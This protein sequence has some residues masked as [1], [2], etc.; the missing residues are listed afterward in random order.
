MRGVKVN[1]FYSL[2]LHWLHIRVFVV[3]YTSTRL[4][5][6]AH[7]CIS[8]KA[9]IRKKR[10]C[11]ILGWPRYPQEP[12]SF[13]ALFTHFTF[14]I[15]SVYVC[16][17]SWTSGPAPGNWT[18]QLTSWCLHTC[19]ETSTTKSGRTIWRLKSSSKTYRSEYKAWFSSAI[20][21]HFSIVIVSV[22]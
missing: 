10:G 20:L 2:H 9:R 17:G 16:V 5:C 1:P 11:S 6:D 4:L 7:W 13:F 12:S 19:W 21:F 8:W 18:H 3:I 22:T 14:H 15:N